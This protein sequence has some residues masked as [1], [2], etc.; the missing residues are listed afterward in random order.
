MCYYVSCIKGK[1]YDQLQGYI[2][3]DGNLLF[4]NIDE[5]ISILHSSFSNLNAA[6][7]AAKTLFELK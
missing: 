6:K 3:E 7:T 1:A 2:G 4:E 5:I